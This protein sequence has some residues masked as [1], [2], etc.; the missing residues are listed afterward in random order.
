LLRTEKPRIRLGQSPVPAT[1]SWNETKTK[2]QL[3]RDLEAD[4]ER[5]ERI[6][7]EKLWILRAPPETASGPHE[8]RRA[9]TEEDAAR[10][11]LENARAEL[12]R[13]R[14]SLRHSD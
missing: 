11:N 5:L 14:R 8:Y 4:L 9:E 13:R 10:R 12:D 7:A 6:H 2:N 1:E 3:C